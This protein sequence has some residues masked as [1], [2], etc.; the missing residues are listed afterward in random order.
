MPR[1]WSARWAPPAVPEALGGLA[2]EAEALRAI[3]RQVFER[4]LQR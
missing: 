4:W 1:P 2:A 3:D